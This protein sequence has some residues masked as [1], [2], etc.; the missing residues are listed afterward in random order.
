MACFICLEKCDRVN[1]CCKQNVCE[2]CEVEWTKIN[3][4]CGHCRKRLKIE[5]TN[6]YKFDRVEHFRYTISQIYLLNADF[7]AR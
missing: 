3:G 1:D 6:P 2:E 4:T 7:Y 5:H